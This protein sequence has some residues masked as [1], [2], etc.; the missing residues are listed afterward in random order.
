MK[1]TDIFLERGCRNVAQAAKMLGISRQAVDEYTKT[2]DRKKNTNRFKVLYRLAINVKSDIIKYLLDDNNFDEHQRHKQSLQNEIE[3]MLTQPPAPEATYGDNRLV[4]R[5]E[6][7]KIFE[8]ITF[9]H[10]KV[11][12]TVKKLKLEGYGEYFCGYIHTRKL[13]AKEYNGLVKAYK[14]EITYR[15]GNVI[16]FDMA[17]SAEFEMK[18]SN[19]AYVC[20]KRLQALIQAYK[21]CEW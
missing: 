6:Q 11:I 13:T 15:E 20:V 12:C 21:V 3:Y 2:T 19:N 1:T 4:K 8:A 9:Q 17:H 16:G 18:L 7:L 10:K 14:Y 5:I